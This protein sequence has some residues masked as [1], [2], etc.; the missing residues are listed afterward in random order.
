LQAPVSLG[1]HVGTMTVTLE[2]QVY[3]EGP[4]VALENIDKA[5][6]WQR[7]MDWLYRLFISLFS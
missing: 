1:Q 2:G 3:Y 4:V 6:L 5:G 7:F